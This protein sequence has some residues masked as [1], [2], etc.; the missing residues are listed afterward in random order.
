MF[1][2]ATAGFAA[3]AKSGNRNHFFLWEVLVKNSRAPKI[4]MGGI[5]G[6]GVMRRQLAAVRGEPALRSAFRTIAGAACSLRSRPSAAAFLKHR[7]PSLN[8]GVY[9]CKT[10]PVYDKKSTS[11]FEE[12]SDPL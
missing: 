4:G 10:K 12:T 7:W 9:F 1:S 6:A 2:L 8:S 3:E 5:G 11:R